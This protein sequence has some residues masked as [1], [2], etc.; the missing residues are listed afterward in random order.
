MDIR[1]L[2]DL[3][4]ND[5]KLKE[6]FYKKFENG[7]IRDAQEIISNNNNLKFEI[8]NSENINNIINKIIYLEKIYGVSTTDMFNNDF[9]IYQNGINNLIYLGE[10][11]NRTQYKINNIIKYENYFYFCKKEPEIGTLPNNETNWVK[12]KLKG[13][14]APED[15]GVHYK[16]KWKLNINYK[17]YDMVILNN[18]I[19]IAKINNI[20]ANPESSIDKWEEQLKINK[21]VIFITQREP[22][23]IKEG[24]LWLQIF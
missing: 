20:G 16:G 15:M 4:I 19:Y 3:G 21:D 8:I 24:N 14:T 6:D 23:N 17:K 22:E 7:N 12:L 9:K 18:K 2:K 5:E 11:N 10:Y 1:I 13:E